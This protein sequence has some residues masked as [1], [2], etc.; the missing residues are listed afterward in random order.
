MEFRS[1]DQPVLD[2]KMQNSLNSLDARNRREE[3]DAVM[4]MKMSLTVRSC[5]V[6]VCLLP[7]ALATAARGDV[8]LLAGD[9]QSLVAATQPGW[10]GM[11]LDT[12][13]VA[14]GTQ[15][16]QLT[17]SGSAAGITATLDGGASWNGRGPDRDRGAVLG[18]S[19]NDVVSDLWFNRQMTAILN[20]TGLLTGT[21][22][23]LRAWH[24]DSYLIN[25]GA[26]AGGGTVT[27]SLVG[28]IVTTASNGTVTNLNG[29]QTDA[30]FGITTLVFTSTASTA[31][32]TFTRNGGSFVGIPISGIQLTTAV[33]PEPV[34]ISLVVGGLVGVLAARRGRLRPALRHL[35]SPR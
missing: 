5:M 32:I 7:S 1:F 30:A 35:R 2:G 11:G 16:L 18:T 10:N 28:G 29:S 31:A 24:N 34:T 19:F 20:L 13:V 25:E 33:V 6:M 14:S 3:P 12:D 27:P 21:Q 15:I 9:L 22:Y 8:M 4:N 17:A 26:A 23:S